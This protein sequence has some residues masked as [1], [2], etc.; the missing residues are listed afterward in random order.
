[1]AETLDA[2][3]AALVD[4]YTL[5][6]ELGHGG[7]ATVCLAEDVEHRRHPAA[8]RRRAWDHQRTDRWVPFAKING[9]RFLSYICGH[10][11]SHGASAEGCML[12]CAVVF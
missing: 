7:M 9:R 10:A 4:R 12:G 3:S 11:R 6:S 2:L 8:H 1:M 5:Q